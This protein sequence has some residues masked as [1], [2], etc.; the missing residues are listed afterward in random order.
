MRTS[1]QGSATSLL[2][3]L[4]IL[5]ATTTT[6]Q[7]DVWMRPY[8]LMSMRLSGH[9]TASPFAPD[10]TCRARHKFNHPRQSVTPRQLACSPIS[11]FGVG[12]I[13]THGGPSCSPHGNIYAPSTICSRCPPF[14]LTNSPCRCKCPVYTSCGRQGAMFKRRIDICVAWDKPRR[15]GRTSACC[16]LVSGHELYAATH[17]ACAILSNLIQI[18]FIHAGRPTETSAR[19]SA[20]AWCLVRGVCCRVNTHTK[21]NFGTFGRG[22]GRSGRR[23]ENTRR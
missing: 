19:G 10:R 3:H 22:K 4:S 12:V 21:N 15:R 7:N 11:I 5:S 2:Q 9:H 14:G 17:A 16:R 6:S 1:T 20:Q 18:P 23:W 13:I 8:S